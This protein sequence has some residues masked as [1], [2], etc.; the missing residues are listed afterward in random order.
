MIFLLSKME[1]ESYTIELLRF[2]FTELN[3]ELPNEIRAIF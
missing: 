3:V 1:L 2:N